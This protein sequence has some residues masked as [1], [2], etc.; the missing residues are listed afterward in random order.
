MAR[1]KDLESGER[2]L[3]ER[4]DEA[5]QRFVAAAGR[6]IFPGGA[7][8]YDR[9]GLSLALESCLWKPSMRTAQKW[10]LALLTFPN[11]P[12]RLIPMLGA[13]FPD[14]APRTLTAFRHAGPRLLF[15]SYP[16]DFLNPGA[17]GD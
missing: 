15:R 9:R 16:V 8:M 14:E 1:Y 7:A 11:H 4:A 17:L 10:L 2:Y 6:K 3:H 12:G 5:F 13:Q